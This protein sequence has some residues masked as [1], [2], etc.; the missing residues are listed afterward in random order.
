MDG[1]LGEMNPPLVMN[2]SIVSDG[3][4]CVDNVIFTSLP[5]ESFFGLFLNKEDVE[6]H[7]LFLCSLSD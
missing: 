2:M 1:L 5:G 7:L 4:C 3:H 6:I